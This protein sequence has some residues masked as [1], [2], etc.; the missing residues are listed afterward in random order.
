MHTATQFRLDSFDI[1]TNGAPTDISLLFPNW[2]EYDRFGLVLNQPYGSLGASLLVQAAIAHFYAAVPARRDESPEYPEIYFFHYG[3]HFGE[4]SNFDVYPPRKEVFIEDAEPTALLAAINER[5]ITRLALPVGPTGDEG[6]LR[7]GPSTWAEQSS[8]RQRL[9][10]CFTY[11]PAGQVDDGDL[12]IRTDDQRLQE[13]VH[14]TLY[15]NE[16]LSNFSALPEVEL[17]KALPG[18]SVAIDFDRY[19]DLVRQRALE[20]PEPVRKELIRLWS[21][22]LAE[23]T[24]TQAYQRI[25]ADAALARISAKG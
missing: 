10:S 8:A 18:P 14:W 2:S 20:I 11:S 25:T 7:A 19:V 5:A 13:N 16:A 12:T 1:Y 22:D 6:A 24:T 9:K 21:V 3:G 4:H 15:P 17:L 23:A